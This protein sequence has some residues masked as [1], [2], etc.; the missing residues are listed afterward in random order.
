MK[1]HL[2]FVHISDVTLEIK[3]KSK[4]VFLWFTLSFFVLILTFFLV[5]PQYQSKAV[6]KESS[7]SQGT[8]SA[9]FL[10]Q[11]TNLSATSEIGN[12]SQQLMLSKNLASKTIDKLSL[13]AQVYPENSLIKIKE[14][15]FQNGTLFFRKKLSKKT[16]FQIKDLSANL[17]DTLFLFVT[18]KDPHHLEIKK[19]SKLIYK[20]LLR[21][22][23]RVENC[24]FSV[25]VPKDF[26]SFGKTYLLKIMT[27]E[28]ALKTF[29]KSLNIK[30]R[31]D[32]PRLLDLS[33]RS[34][35]SALAAK[36]L[37]THMETYKDYLAS[38]H[39]KISVEQLNFLAKRQEEIKKSLKQSLEN[40]KGYI[41]SQYGGEAFFSLNQQ[42]KLF[43]ERKKVLLKDLTRL[44]LKLSHIEG[45]QC[46][47]NENFGERAQLTEL[48]KRKAAFLHRGFS[49]DLSDYIKNSHE[50]EPFLGFVRLQKPESKIFSSSIYKEFFPGLQEIKQKFSLKK[51]NDEDAI[52]NKVSELDR[53]A[54]LKIEA[55][56]LLRQLKMGESIHLERTSFSN[57]FD[58]ATLLSA[59][60]TETKLIQGYLESYLEMVQLEERL[61]SSPFYKK[62]SDDKAFAGLD[63]KTI[64][65]LCVE[66]IDL[67]EQLKLQTQQIDLALEH[68][69]IKK[70]DPN[71]LATTNLP[72]KGLQK[73]QVLIKVSDELKD[74]SM[75]TL[76]EKQRLV[77][78]LKLEERLFIEYLRYQ[79]KLFESQKE[80]GEKKLKAIKKAQFQQLETE[81]ALIENQIKKQVNQEVSSLRKE[82]E[83]IEEKLSEIKQK[84]RS[85][86]Q[87]WLLEN[88]LKF[89]ADLNLA[90]MESITRLVESKNIDHHL[91]Q[92]GSGPV[93]LAEASLAPIKRR[94]VLWSV[95]GAIFSSLIYLTVFLFFRIRKGLVLS[96]A[97]AEDRNVLV[98]GQYDENKLQEDFTT[99]GDRDLKS[100]RNICCQI[101]QNPVKV[102]SLFQRQGPSYEIFLA[103]LMSLSDQK[104]LIVEL[105]SGKE[106]EGGLLHAILEA[107]DTLVYEKIGKIH[108]LP[109][110]GETKYL[111]ELL[112]RPFFGQLL[113]SWKKRYDVVFLVTKEGY[114]TSFSKNLFHKADF[115]VLSLNNESIDDLQ[116]FVGEKKNFG[117]LFSKMKL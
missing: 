8:N 48:K 95:I 21:E 87:K 44:S 22:K 47:L 74:Q 84:S 79:K 68:L 113:E 9:N 98:F 92:I 102:V 110:G 52:Q 7:A 46:P 81:I 66:T 104:V 26:K 112:A 19:G 100:L 1:E 5:E 94:P 88:E 101:R 117:L 107:E 77:K 3:N 54:R 16:L 72:Q 13:K 17:E 42:M 114:N 37:N 115:S 25:H 106:S 86:P 73:L 49:K 109:L 59:K 91:M 89:D 6:F 24:S 50:K 11:L 35:D 28:D 53:I 103:H 10:K 75:L 55:K 12:Y 38:D 83:F 39:K 18:I 60:N 2:E 99:L 34:T 65:K 97:G 31:K 36:V 41:K 61:L 76:K 70:Y 90:T 58:K 63:L 14:D 23:I 30:V 15:L 57:V 69:Q 29:F 116:S 78:K 64:D 111:T 45:S 32:E 105:F 51:Q 85:I 71:A 43:E 80:I 4:K 20:G 27:K 96:L 62:G 40:Y 108:K 93:D 67:L 82:K 33:F 56:T